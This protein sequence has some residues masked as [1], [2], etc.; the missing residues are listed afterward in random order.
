[1]GSEE[2]LTAHCII[3]HIVLDGL[4]CYYSNKPARKVSTPASFC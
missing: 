3:T 4:C 2:S 1:M